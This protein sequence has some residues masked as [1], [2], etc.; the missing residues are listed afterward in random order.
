MGLYKARRIERQ[1]CSHPHLV[2]PYGTPSV[3]RTLRSD[4]LSG[5]RIF[6]HRR[7]S[8]NSTPYVCDQ[9]TSS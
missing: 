4:I 1:R 3:H 5:F 2:M 9:R 8:A 7:N 6:Y